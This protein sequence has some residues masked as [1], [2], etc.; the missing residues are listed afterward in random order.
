LVYL[1]RGLDNSSG[2]QVTVTSESWGPLQG[3]TIH[4][5]FGTGSHFLVLRDQ[6]N[7]QVQG[8]VV[9]LPGEFLSGTH[10]GRFH[11]M[12]GQLYVSGMQG[13]GTYTPDDGCFDRVRFLGGEVQLPTGFHVHE[14]GIAITF[15]LPL[16]DAT[17]AD[18]A[19]HFAQAWN[20]R[21][22]PG[23]GS[24][25]FSAKHLGMRGHDSMA[26]RSAHV[27]PGG[28][29]L[30]VEIPELQPVNQLHL[31]VQS[32]PGQFHELFV[33]VH[34]LDQPFVDLPNYVATK[35]TI[36]PHPILADLAMATRSVPNPSRHSIDGARA[37]TIETGTNLSYATRSF[38]V[39]AGEPLALTFDNPDVV[40]HN[41]A[42][43]KPGTLE[44]VGVLA[45]QSISDPE[46]ALH[47][48]VPSTTDV[49][50]YTDVVLPGESFTIYF[51]APDQP[52]RYPYLCTF[53]G[54][55]K[56]MN[57]EMVVEPG[58]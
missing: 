44:R 55:W 2:G 54:H 53:P 36:S 8:A 41:W 20:Y 6:V 45:D 31:R 14:N 30:F 19:N 9:P 35:K 13:W 50:A 32:A 51:H 37:V 3:Q 24:A 28:R 23:Y 18:A 10:R 33:T 12:D 16:D 4:L 27:L 26:I 21:Y 34:E 29:T 57:G 17:A 15:S 42:L 11:P 46:A 38:R 1:P 7:G 48:Y 49:L 52:G 39:R 47:H 25:E 22:G 58:R 56:I 40:P 43:A 5:S